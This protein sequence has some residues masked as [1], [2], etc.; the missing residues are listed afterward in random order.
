MNK[1][2]GPEYYD[3]NNSYYFLVFQNLPSN[4]KS[5]SLNFSPHDTKISQ[6]SGSFVVLVINV[7]SARNNFLAADGKF[8]F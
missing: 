1:S 7:P 5:G 6:F 3:M 2:I 4:P 8:I